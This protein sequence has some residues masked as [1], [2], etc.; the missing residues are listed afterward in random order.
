MRERREKEHERE[1]REREREI[2][3]KKLELQNN[4]ELKKLETESKASHADTEC[5][6]DVTKFIR[7]VP[8]FQDKDVDQ[9]FLHFEKIANSLKWPKE[10]WCLLLQSVFVGKAR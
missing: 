6:F 8:P 9:Y 5:K 4:V 10:F 7:S 3:L 1:E 2:E